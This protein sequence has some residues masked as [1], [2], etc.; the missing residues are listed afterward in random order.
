MWWTM[1]PLSVGIALFSQSI[2]TLLYGT[3]YNASASVLAIHVFSNIPV[4][5]GVAQGIWIINEAKNTLSLSKTVIG[6][7]SN[8]LLNL[9]LIP[10][11]GALGAAS[12][13][14]CSQMIAAVVSNI[15]L[16]PAIFKKQIISIAGWQK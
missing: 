15:F 9:L 4:A 10:K 13:T 6:A 2:I 8:V 7:I 5:L 11:Y 14:V 16:D 3:V 12:A 1:L